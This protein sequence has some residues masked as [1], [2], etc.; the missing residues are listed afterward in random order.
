MG[1]LLFTWLRN[2]EQIL[3]SPR[4]GQQ[5]LRMMK[6]PLHLPR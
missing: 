4:V 5:P 3:V 1:A 2:S 6:T